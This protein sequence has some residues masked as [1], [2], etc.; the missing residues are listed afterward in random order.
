MRASSKGTSGLDAPGGRRAWPES[1]PRTT[2]CQRVVTI[3][4]GSSRTCQRVEHCL[5]R[6]FFRRV[7]Q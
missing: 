3:A 2:M 4:D 5:S 1:W 6:G 7:D